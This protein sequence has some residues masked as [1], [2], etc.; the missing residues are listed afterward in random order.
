MNYALLTCFDTRFLA[1]VGLALTSFGRAAGNALA[2]EGGVARCGCK[3]VV[4][5]KI[6]K[7]PRF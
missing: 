5:P 7:R 2:G 3:N 6:E 1:G 4:G